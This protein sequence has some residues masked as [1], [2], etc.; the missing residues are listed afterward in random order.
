MGEK[1]TTDPPTTGHRR[2]D[3]RSIEYEYRDA[4]YE[5][6]SNR[7]KSPSSDLASAKK[8]RSRSSQR[9]RFPPRCGRSLTE[10]PGRPKICHIGGDLRSAVSAGSETRAEQRDRAEQC[11]EQCDGYFLADAYGGIVTASTNTD[12]EM[13]HGN[14]RAW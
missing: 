6:E 14:F 1:P 12:G 8:L 4:E 2:T 3:A 13:Q 11:A 9:S 5:Y 10:P 7:M